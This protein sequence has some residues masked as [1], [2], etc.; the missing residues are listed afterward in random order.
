MFGEVRGSRDAGGDSYN[1]G[2]VLG[3]SR[4]WLG[5]VERPQKEKVREEKQTEKR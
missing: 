2:F 5:L 1:L 4:N 3:S